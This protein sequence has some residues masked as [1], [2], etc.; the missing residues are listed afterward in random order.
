MSYRAYAGNRQSTRCL[1]RLRPDPKGNPTAPTVTTQSSDLEALRRTRTTARG[2]AIGCQTNREI[3][4]VGVD[5]P[6]Y[7][8]EGSASLGARGCL[9][10]DLGLGTSWP[11]SVRGGGTVCGGA[12]GRTAKG[13]F[14]S[15]EHHG[16]GGPAFSASGWTGISGTVQD[17]GLGRTVC[18]GEQAGRS[19]AR[20]R[21]IRRGQGSRGERSVTPCRSRPWSRGTKVV[22]T[23]SSSDS[24]VF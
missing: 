5:L 6:G 10:V 14:R 11:G 2:E 8:R 3:P 7:D 12:I 1:P 9:G 4:I 16:R 20:R 17:V 18:A 21:R 23:A 19:A 13:E 22:E 15:D 24:P